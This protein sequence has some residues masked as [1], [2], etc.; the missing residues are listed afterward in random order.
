MTRRH[1]AA[2]LAATTLAFA[3]S[4][5]LARPEPETIFAR[6]NHAE[7]RTLR[8]EQHVTQLRISLVEQ[9]ARIQRF[10]HEQAELERSSG[11]LRHKAVKRQIAW[12]QVRREADRVALMTPP[13][14]DERLAALLAQVE[15]AA[16][17]T[18]HREL[19]ALANCHEARVHLTSLAMRRAS[20][21]L[22][23]A[24]HQAL[25]QTGQAEKAQALEHAKR[26]NADEVARDLAR[27]QEQLARALSLGVKNT[28]ER[29][30]HR[31]KGTLIAP[32]KQAPAHTFGPRKLGSTTTYTRHTGYTYTIPVGTPVRATAAGVIAY[33]ATFE[34]Y[35]NVIIIDHGAGYHSVYAHMSR[36]AVELGQ[37]VSRGDTLGDSGESGSLEGPKLYFELRKQGQPINPA[38]WFIR[39]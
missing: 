6:I 22:A 26:A 13:A 27:T 38:D 18:Q 34:G 16:H 24:Q 19:A 39:R 15:P 37:K 1:L 17:A 4:A 7:D 31:F 11:R 28:E 29:D 10:I 2:L 21:T 25:A 5:A 36:F 14:A 9:D 23:L 20:T 12:E 3:T 8:A 30:F 33:A 35:G 32:V